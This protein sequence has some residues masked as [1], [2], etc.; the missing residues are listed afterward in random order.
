MKQTH[1]AKQCYVPFQ[2]DHP[3][4]NNLYLIKIHDTMLLEGFS[5]HLGI[6]QIPW[7]LWRP[8]LSNQFHFISFFKKKGINNKQHNPLLQSSNMVHVYFNFGH[9]LLSVIHRRGCSC[10]VCNLPFVTFPST[11]RIGPPSK[12]LLLTLIPSPPRR[13][14]IK[15]KMRTR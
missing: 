9:A 7:A 13:T 11:G 3:I 12:R 4:Y 2:L 6:L 5:Y 15:L 14:I 8:G 10:H 1:M